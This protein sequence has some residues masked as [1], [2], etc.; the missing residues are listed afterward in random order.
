MAFS[1]RLFPAGDVLFISSAIKG[2]VFTPSGLFIFPTFCQISINLFSVDRLT[3][4]QLE[5]FIVM[6]HV[7]QVSL[8]SILKFQLQ[9]YLRIHGHWCWSPTKIWLQKLMTWCD[10]YLNASPITPCLCEHLKV[11]FSMEVVFNVTLD[12]IPMLR[13]VFTWNW[14]NITWKQDATYHLRSTSTFYEWQR[15]VTATNPVLKRLIMTHESIDL[16][17]RRWEKLSCE[18]HV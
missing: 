18:E 17:G 9:P 16:S 11:N 8:Q 10:I 13:L 1:T 12:F 7:P 2:T 14:G 4:T 5:N 3:Q 15:E 6:L